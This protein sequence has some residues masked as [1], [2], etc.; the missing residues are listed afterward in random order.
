MAPSWVVAILQSRV[1]HL[2]ARVLMVTTFLVPGIMQPLQFQNA[3]GEFIHFNLHPPAVYVVA[4]FITLLAGSALVVFGGKWT[5]LGA[6]AL[7]IYTGLTIF[8]AHHFWTMSGPDRLSEMRTMLEHISLIGGL[9]AIAIWK[10]G[11]AAAAD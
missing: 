11:G 8:I 5:W 6:G 1:F 9:M 4:S 10:N 2:V 7:G 3:I